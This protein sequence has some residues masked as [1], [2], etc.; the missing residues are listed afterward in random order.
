VYNDTASRL[1]CLVPPV[2][3]PSYVSIHAATAPAA[4]TVSGLQ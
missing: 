4:T 2:L 3:S 1:L